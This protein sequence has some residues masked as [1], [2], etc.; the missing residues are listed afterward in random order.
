MLTVSEARRLLPTIRSRVVPLRLGRVPDDSVR[1]FGKSVLGVEGKALE[2]LV[3]KADGAI[4]QVAG[5]RDTGRKATELAEGWLAASRGGALE[6][7]EAV[8]RQPSWSARGEFSDALGAL[9]AL[10]VV[11]ARRNAEEANDA[12]RDTAVAL[13]HVATARERAQGNVNPQLLLASI[14]G[15][16]AQ[17]VGRE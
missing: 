10:L 11:Q 16:M 17:D 7:A 3:T 8:L 12:L 2:A 9:E 4:G 5:A 13:G 15:R 1:R 14:L 6:R